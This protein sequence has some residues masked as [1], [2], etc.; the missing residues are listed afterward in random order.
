MSKVAIAGWALLA[1]VLVY[2]VL[3]AR[4]TSTKLAM[5][6]VEK[7]SITAVNDSLTTANA[8][9]VQAVANAQVRVA[10]ADAAALADSL[11]ADARIGAAT[12]RADDAEDRMRVALEDRPDLAALFDSVTT[13]HDVELNAE[14]DRAQRQDNLR[15]AQIASR[16]DLILR[17]RDQID[18]QAA[19]IS[20]QGAIIA[21]LEE[22]VSTATGGFNLFGI[23]TRCVA[24]IGVTTGTNTSAGL[25][26]ACGVGL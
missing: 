19:I 6:R 16:D 3:S 17:Q 2:G 24:G 13:A 7:D 5:L 12:R 21:N 23:K 15:L 10:E 14:R 9:H 20:T 11:E 26:I 18:T 25:S 8:V 4:D 1:V 22:Q